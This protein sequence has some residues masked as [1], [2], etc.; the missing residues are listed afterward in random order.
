MSTLSLLLQLFHIKNSMCFNF[1]ERLQI[2]TMVRFATVFA[3]I[4]FVVAADRNGTSHLEE[5]FLA[6]GFGG[7]EISGCRVKFTYGYLPKCSGGD[8]QYFEMDFDLKH[9]HLGEAPDVTAVTSP[10]MTNHFLSFRASPSYLDTIWRLPLVNE[11][12][13][14]LFPGAARPLGGGTRVAERADFIYSHFPRLGPFD[15]WIIHSCYGESPRLVSELNIPFLS[16]ADA[17]SVWRSLETY[18]SAAG[19]LPA[20]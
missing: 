19:C 17:I 20:R 7:V 4:P 10:T 5:A 2:W 18:S 14:K 1:H 12:A 13:D 9:W 8:Q 11:E 16:N 6:A 15:W 3:S